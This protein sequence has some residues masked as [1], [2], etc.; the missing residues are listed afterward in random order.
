V[1]P[2]RLGFARAA[3]VAAA[4]LGLAACGGG[5][6]SPQVLADQTTKAVYNDDVNAI[7]AKF[8]DGLKRMVTID[9]VA[10]I[11]S[12]LHALGSYKGLTQTSADAPAGRYDYNASF[13]N[14]TVAVHLRL[15]PSGQI[16]AY[17]L[18]IPQSTSAQASTN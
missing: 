5:G 7:Q 13:D 12:K 10:T 9:Q 14:A 8:D 6:N 16:A 2:P 1:N 11:S 3:A 18:D 15:D 17:R 4:L